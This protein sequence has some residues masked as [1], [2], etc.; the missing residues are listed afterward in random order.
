MIRPRSRTPGPWAVVGVSI[1]A[2]GAATFAIVAIGTLAPK[3]QA[4]LGFSRAE[5]GVLTSLI[6][7][8]SVRQLVGGRQREWPTPIKFG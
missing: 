8:G 5:I 6:F 2:L 1:I 4:A 3:L 7:V